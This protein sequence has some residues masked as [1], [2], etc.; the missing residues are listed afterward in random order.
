M[1]DLSFY[2][3]G[4][5]INKQVRLIKQYNDARNL[6]TIACSCGQL[7]A[8]EMA[9]RC[10]YCGEWFCF[11]CAEIHFGETVLEWKGKKRIA[12]YKELEGLSV[13]Q[14]KDRIRTRVGC[15]KAR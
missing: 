6:R 12:H 13:E 5:D 15:N 3:L 8:L 2:L 11:P 14:I 1:S 10:L 9:Y 4:A 7:R